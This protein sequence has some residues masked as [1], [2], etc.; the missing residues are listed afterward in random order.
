MKGIVVRIV[1]GLL[2]AYFLVFGIMLLFVSSEE[3]HKLYTDPLGYEPGFI[4]AV[5]AVEVIGALGLIAGFKWPKLALISSGL[6]ALVMA[7][8]VCSHLAAGQGAA[9][10]SI[11]FVL[12]LLALV[13]LLGRRS[14]QRNSFAA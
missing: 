9:E 10:A 7:G 6:L 12:L 11:P 8:A 14:I 4:Y 13:V 1:Q 2:A 3:I 5:K